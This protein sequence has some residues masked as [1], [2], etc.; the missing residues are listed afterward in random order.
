FESDSDNEHRNRFSSVDGG[1]SRVGAVGDELA[2]LCRGVGATRVRT[3]STRHRELADNSRRDSKR[4]MRH[5]RR[6]GESR[7]R[8]TQGEKRRVRSRDRSWKNAGRAILTFALKRGVPGKIL[9]K[10]VVEAKRGWP[11]K[12]T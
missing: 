2:P 11:V 12:A 7:S 6:S 1:R 8:T 10:D 3:R 4:D 9:K 5:R